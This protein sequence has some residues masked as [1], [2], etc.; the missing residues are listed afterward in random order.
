V[1]YIQGA[2]PLDGAGEL[3]LLLEGE[4]IAALGPAAELVCPPGAERLEAAG[5]FIAPGFIDLQFNG[6]FGLD[7]T[8]APESIWEVGRRLP[9]FG[10]TAFL[11]TII[12]SPPATVAAA[13]SVLRAGPPAGYQGATA[14][15]LHLE[16]PFLNLAKRGA[17]NAS[18]MRPPSLAA[19]AD[20]SPA[21]GVRLVTLAPELPGALDVITALCQR[22]VVMSAG[23][24]MAN[25]EQA[26]AGLHAGIRYGTHL[27]N[28]MPPLD[29]RAPGLA[30]ALLTDAQAT[31]GL[32]PDGIHL[33]PAVVKL[34][35]QSKGPAGVN[36]VTDAMAALGQPSGRYRLGDFEVVVDERSARL[37]DGRLAG[38]IVSLDQAVRN[39]ITYTGCSPQAAVDSVTKVPARVL[40]LPDYGV[41]RV[42]AR[43]DLVLLT[44]EMAV[45]A[46]W[47]GGRAVW[48]ASN[49]V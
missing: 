41:L 8:A 32:I 42:G 37:S 36:V 30:A 45:A 33:H 48:P 6:G 27:F 17:H 9:R 49:A 22:G 34:I 44:P 21:Q 40:G 5:K 13:Q 20:W 28:A 14:L 19:V 26:Q 10:V 18:L 11:P 3:S 25:F 16:G 4:R 39:T 7:F 2:R 31:V 1:L 29:H 24:S 35:W 38:S 46:T 23:H 47:V 43:A 12:T 15:G